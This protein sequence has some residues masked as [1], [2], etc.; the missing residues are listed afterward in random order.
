MVIHVGLDHPS[1]FKIMTTWLYITT[2]FNFTDIN[3]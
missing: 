1:G 2:F 3:I